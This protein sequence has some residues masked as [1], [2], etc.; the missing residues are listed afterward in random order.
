MSDS[1]VEVQNIID[2]EWREAA[3]G[4]TYDVNNPAHPDEVVGR[5]ALA[6]QDDVKDAIEAA[7]C[8]LAQ[9]RVGHRRAAVG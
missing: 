5:A 7:R 2:G 3:G 9:Y 1:L 8:V 4:R 6:N